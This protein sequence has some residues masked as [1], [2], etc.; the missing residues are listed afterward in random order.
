MLYVYFGIFIVCL[1]SKTYGNLLIIISLSDWLLS[2]IWILPIV[3]LNLLIQSIPNSG[4]I[5]V[6]SVIRIS[7]FCLLFS[8]SMFTDIFSTISFPFHL[9][10]GIGLLF[11]VFRSVSLFVH[12]AALS[13]LRIR[14]HL[15]IYKVFLYSD[16]FYLR[17]VMF[18][19]FFKILFCL[20]FDVCSRPIRS[21]IHLVRLF[22]CEV[23][24]LF[25]CCIVFVDMHLR[26]VPFSRSY[27][28]SIFQGDIFVLGS[29]SGCYKICMVV[30]R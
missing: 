23:F 17:C 4:D 30:F 3:S 12:R 6:L 16:Y 25:G 9:R 21:E 19:F 22:L 28:T 7:I 2:A 13:L 5:S 1:F 15:Q 20:L 8:Y 10:L 26:S 29:S 24:S 18:L 11:S 27:C 14:Y